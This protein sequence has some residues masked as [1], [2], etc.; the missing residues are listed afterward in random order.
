MTRKKYLVRL[1]R[2][3]RRSIRGLDLP[4]SIKL[5]KAFDNGGNFALTSTLESLGFTV[6]WEHAG[7]CYQGH[8]EWM[9]IVLRDGRIAGEFFVS[10]DG[11]ILPCPIKIGLSC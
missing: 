8:D 3:L 1:A 6:S 10:C 2:T 4:A 11:A 9:C 5:A 7:Q